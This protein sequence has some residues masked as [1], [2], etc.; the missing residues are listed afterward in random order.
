[1]STVLTSTRPAVVDFA[2]IRIGTVDEHGEVR[3]FAGIHIG[4]VRADDP[5]VAVDFAG[6][7]LGRVVPVEG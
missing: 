7:R 5:T 3:D 1:M 4:A 2:G 6:I